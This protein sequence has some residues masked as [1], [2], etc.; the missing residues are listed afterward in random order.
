MCSY[1]TSTIF[2]HHVLYIWFVLVKSDNLYVCVYVRLFYVFLL[3]STQVYFC[4]IGGHV[5]YWGL[6][7]I[8]E[9]FHSDQ[10]Q[11]G[12]FVLFF[13]KIIQGIWLVIMDRFVHDIL[14]ATPVH[15][16]AVKKTDFKKPGLKITGCLR[17]ILLG[18]CLM[19]QQEWRN[20]AEAMWADTT[21]HVPICHSCSRC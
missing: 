3:F 10:S 19:V 16:G 21:I 4:C 20:T 12:V 7:L 13:G 2:Q 11:S 1:T 14:S 6:L 5:W 17:P 9:D 18:G 15:K 8:E